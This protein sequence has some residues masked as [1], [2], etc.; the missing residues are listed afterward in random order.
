MKPDAIMKN[1]YEIRDAHAKSFGYKLPAIAADLRN[2]ERESGHQ[3]A[4]L[5]I[6]RKTVKQA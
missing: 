3:L 5:A 2:K 4:R 6:K 1:L